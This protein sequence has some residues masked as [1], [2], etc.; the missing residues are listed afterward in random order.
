[1]TLRPTRC[2]SASHQT[3]D[4]AGAGAYAWAVMSRMPCQS[5]RSLGALLGL[6]LMVR[7]G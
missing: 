6:L 7:T 2:R 5:G 1:M 3:I 4:T